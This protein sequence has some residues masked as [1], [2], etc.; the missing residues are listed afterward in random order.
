MP[1]QNKCSIT[2][3]SH[4][5]HREENQD[6]FSVLQNS[7][8]QSLLCVVADGMGGHKGSALAAQTVIETANTLWQEQLLRASI[9]IEGVESFLYKLVSESHLA[10]NKVG[11]ANGLEPRST[12]AALYLYKDGEH[13][14]AISIHAG[15]SRITQYSNTQKIAQSFDHSL[16][17]L[18]VLQGKITEEELAEDPD[19]GTVISN[20]G[21]QDL[22]DPE[23][24][25]WDLAKGERF[26]VCSD[27]FWEIFSTEEVLALFDTDSKEADAIIEA[28]LL[29]KMKER[30]KHDNTTV[31]M[32]EINAS[33]QDSLMTNSNQDDNEH[34]PMPEVEDPITNPGK[35]E[36]VTESRVD[37]ASSPDSQ[38]TRPSA[39]ISSDASSN[40]GSTK[41]WLLIAG[42]IVVLAGLVMI[43][44]GGSEEAGSQ[45]TNQSENNDQSQG[46]DGTLEE[47]ESTANQANGEGGEGLPVT[48]DTTPATNSEG[49]VREDRVL[50]SIQLETAIEVSSNEEL[51]AEITDMLLLNDRLGPND[52]LSISTEGEVNG[53]RIIRLEQTHLG[54]P[55]FGA[56]VV[57][58]EI[59][60]NVFNI[61]GSTGNDI[62]INVEPEL[63]FDQALDLANQSLA[64]AVSPRAE[65]DAAQLIIVEVEGTYHLA[66]YIEVVIEGAQ[67]RVF[68]DAQDGAVL[69]RLPVNIGEA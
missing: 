50:D 65:T 54:I 47:A 49:A 12:L 25:H 5:G 43:M 23:I 35:R 69:M 61:S 15:D 32:V 44:S 60:G 18:K 56:E 4:I 16:A 2:S 14:K 45:N 27:G 19:Q 28:A 62:E 39:T 51:I 48:Q 57:A 26:T 22:P 10:V 20:I 24:T 68:L 31:I 67:E 66:W 7:E 36:A 11:E 46:A 30:P 34:Q 1:S 41:K 64:M 58:V 55:V 40:A 6:R 8:Q 42:V 59:N 21:G 29:E 9:D 13:D 63:S 37:S 52:A 38:A 53:N 33:N 3:F 17:Q